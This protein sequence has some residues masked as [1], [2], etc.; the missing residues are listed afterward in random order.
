[1]KGIQRKVGHLPNPESQVFSLEAMTIASFL[2]NL[3]CFA[4][5]IATS[6]PPNLS[7]GFVVVSA[8]ESIPTPSGL[9]GHFATSSH[10]FIGFSWPVFFGVCGQVLLPSLSL[11][12]LLK[13]VHRGWPCQYSKYQWHSF[14]HQSY[15]QPSEL[16]TNRRVDKWLVRL[17]ELE[18]NL[19]LGS[20]STES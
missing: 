10:L 9:P 5:N 20:E 15:M 13:P 4:L 2:W 7:K 6:F 18:R 14:Q 3:N 19:G 17:P 11:E 8:T 16:T 12:G 1:M